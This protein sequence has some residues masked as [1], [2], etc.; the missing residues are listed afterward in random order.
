MTSTFDTETI[1]LSH[2]LR[3]S[4]V[5]GEEGIGRLRE[6]VFRNCRLTGPIH[7]RV[8]SNVTLTE[9]NFV[10]SD[11][12]CIETLTRSE[13]YVG[14]ADVEDCTFESCTFINVKLI[15]PP[16]ATDATG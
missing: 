6:S 5:L 7:L 3:S 16:E 14:A 10:P 13:P 8:G 12:D 11:E 4:P 9:C 2:L 1:A 15:V